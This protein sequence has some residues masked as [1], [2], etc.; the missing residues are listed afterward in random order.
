MI[1][2]AGAD[3]AT[4]NITSPV[5][6]KIIFE[7]PPITVEVTTTNQGLY[8][9]Y[10][11]SMNQP[12]DK[13][14]DKAVASV[15]LIDSNNDYIYSGQYPPT[16][17]RVHRQCPVPSIQGNK[18]YS[19]FDP[20]AYADNSGTCTY[21][22]YFGGYKLTANSQGETITRI[23]ETEP[24]FNVTC[25]EDCPEGSHKCTHNKYPG[26]CCVPCKKVAN[27]INNIAKKVGR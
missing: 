11:H 2:C 4:I 16:D 17:P 1:Y 10:T 19:D 5:I 15:I 22:V 12:I 7:N 18:I 20:G 8:Q 3:K 14:F 9:D 25:D 26:Y 23:Y 27:R 24:N 13:T 6:E 21:R